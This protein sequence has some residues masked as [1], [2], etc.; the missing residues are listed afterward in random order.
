MVEEYRTGSTGKALEG[1]DLKID[2]PDNDGNGE[3]LIRGRNLFMGYLNLPE[4][5]AGEFDNEG[6]L[7]T[8]DI[9][10][11]DADGFL[12]ITG[13]IK[14][15]II[16]AGG[17]NVPP[18]QLEAAVKANVP[19]ISNAM[20]IGDKRR[21]L[22]CLLTL[23]C[24]F[25][26]DGIPLDKLTPPVIKEFQDNG[27]TCTTVKEAIEDPKVK[28]LIERGIET[29]NKQATS[30]AQTLRKWALLPVDFSVAGNELGPTMKLKRRV[31]NKLYK[32]SSSRECACVSLCDL[33]PALA[34]CVASH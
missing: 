20:V 28:D 34:D 23:K 15:L 24:E 18:L 33:F 8:G 5:S 31:V 17:E 4:K 22:I 13:R 30:N 12:T 11:L 21:F 26:E 6:Y 29:V 7:H 27:I 32:V 9:G 19:V 1:T 16:T 25:D 2:N 14:E 3:I 10:K